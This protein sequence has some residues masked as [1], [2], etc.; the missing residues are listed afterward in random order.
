MAEHGRLPGT[1]MNTR[2]KKTAGGPFMER[3]EGRTLL[4]GEVR[5]VTGVVFHD[6]NGNFVPDVGETTFDNLT[7]FDD[8][9][10]N[11][12]FDIDEPSAVTDANGAYS[13]M[14][15]AQV[16]RLKVTPPANWVL[17][18]QV[19]TDPDVRNFPI[20]PAPSLSGSAVEDHDLDRFRDS[21]DG[22]VAG[23]LVFVD[24]DADNQLDEG[25]ETTTTDE[26]GNYLF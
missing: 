1:F 2:C 19:M 5:E 4:S 9:N 7:I 12:T 26:E 21:E 22:G 8:V 10:D 11:G 13:L 18:V 14:T 3:L 23:M 15:D 17:R 24:R 6:L 20:A 25:E 16:F